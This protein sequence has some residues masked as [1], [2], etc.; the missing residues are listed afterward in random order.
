MPH[1]L[2]V[3][4]GFPPAAKSSAYRLRVMANLFAE[5][6]W[7]VTVLTIDERSWERE[8]GLDHS[9]D[10]L[11]HPAITQVQLPLAREDL[12]TDIRAYG[13]L[14]ARHTEL[15]LRLRRRRDTLSFPE[16]VFGSWRRPL[17]HGA[18][19]V[20]AR[21]PV[22]LVLATPAPY[23]SLAAAL[24]LHE[25]HTVPFVVDF[26]DAWSLDV[27]GQNEKFSVTS[28]PGR[29][30]RRAVEGALQVWTVNDPI[31]QWYRERFPAHA[32]KVRVARNGFDADIAAAGAV[33]PVE[34]TPPHRRP[35]VFGYLGTAQLQAAHVADLIAGWQLARG[36]DAELRDARLVFRGHVGVG[37][38]KG[39]NALSDLIENASEH[40]VEYGGP[41]P[42]AEV[43]RVYAQW[44]AL[45]LL[46][47]GGRYMTTGKVYEYLST[48]L[49][50]VSSHAPDHDAATV[51]EG[52]PLWARCTGTD[53]EA[54]SAAFT[55]GA[56]LALQVTPTLRG[57]ALAFAQRYE[58]R[59]LLAPR[60][61]EVAALVPPARGRVAQSL[62]D[63]PARGESRG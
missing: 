63:A 24:V 56:R 22:D 39:A 14:R 62:T 49:P 34:G 28:R 21:H 23:V 3:A 53:P 9:L 58:R 52:Y 1:L 48:G 13:W 42:K 38:T 8:F 36:R 29:W 40:G 2:Y 27:M 26:R 59:H 25:Q 31:A 45:V 12:A 51:L 44:D 30:E 4:I 32:A 20:H 35:L 33:A 11:V 47:P 54:M 18:L 15:W 5:T 17:E 7:D 46:V 55:A 50:I 61:Q 10:A 41:V 37:A 16:P 57:Q 6:G 19:D 60:I 43:G